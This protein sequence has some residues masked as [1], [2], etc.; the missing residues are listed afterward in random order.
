[1]ICEPE[2]CT[3]CFACYNICPKNAIE[4]IKDEFGNIYPQINEEKCIKCNLCQNKCPAKND[5]KFFKPKKCFAAYSKD[6]KI[7]ETS[8]SGGVAYEFYKFIL[9]NNGIAY[10]VSSY[11]N[12]NE[13]IFERIDKIDDLIRLQ[14]SKY[15]HAY[16]KDC[17]KKVQKDLLTGKDVIFIGTPCQVD[18]L[19]NFLGKDFDNL[20]TV[21]LICHGVPSQKLLNE[22][23]RKEFN[24][25]KFRGIKGFY[26]IAQKDEKKVY[27]KSRYR[28]EYYNAFLK[29]SIYRENCYNCKYA[30]IQRI[31]DITIG[32]F[33]GLN[34]PNISISK[35]SVIL[36]NTL[37][38]EKFLNKIDNIYKYSEKI[39]DAVQGNTQ[40]RQ[41]SSK[42]KQYY[43]FR[44]N[45]EKYG[46]KKVIRKSLSIKEKCKNLKGEIKTN[47]KNILRR[48]YE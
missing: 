26:L 21:D 8:S 43:Y 39:E 40:L 13:I 2:K 6:N 9:T 34:D 3:G 14:G 42:N 25:V 4:M 41:P 18:G 45:Y 10:G 35:V 32:D 19:K 24:F 30:Q 38:G 7:A 29:A 37:K 36:V 12:D 5:S 17:Y 23:I 11:L 46:L 16:I 47:L 20:V 1:M 33:W 31:S 22:Q 28:S 27:K 48:K 15:V 44:N